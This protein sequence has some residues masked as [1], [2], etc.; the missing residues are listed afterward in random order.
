MKCL[1][2]PLFN[3]RKFLAFFLLA[4][5]TVFVNWYF[6]KS[7]RPAVRIPDSVEIDPSAR[8][9]DAESLSRPYRYGYKSGFEAFLKQTGRDVPRQ[10]VASYTSSETYEMDDE[11]VER[12]YVDG[13][14]KATE[15]QNCPRSG[16]EY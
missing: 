7:E 4:C 1:L 9:A 3:K 5:A 16:Y 8:W 15:L 11:E 13:Y 14:H 12:G 6:R 10:M 2:D